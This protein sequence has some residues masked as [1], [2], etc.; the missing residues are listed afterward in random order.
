MKLR[1][2]TKLS[3]GI[4]GIADNAMYTMAGTFLLPP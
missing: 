4:G 2:R 3:Y 1:F